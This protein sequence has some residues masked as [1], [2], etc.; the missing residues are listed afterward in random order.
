MNQELIIQ[1]TKVESRAL[2]H[3]TRALEVMLGWDVDRMASQ[4][5]S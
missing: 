1:Q 4:E 2:E 3:V 5:N